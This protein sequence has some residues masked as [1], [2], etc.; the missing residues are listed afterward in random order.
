MKKPS[1]HVSKVS[2]HLRESRF[3]NPGNFWLWNLES[4][5]FLPMESRIL[6]FGIRIQPKE[7]RIQVQ[8][9]KTGINYLDCRIHSIESRIQ[10]CLGFPYKGQE[11][12]VL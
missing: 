11:V 4:G 5:I 7:Y 6:G 10:D 9:T 8:L 3:Q 1:C 2:P 12:S